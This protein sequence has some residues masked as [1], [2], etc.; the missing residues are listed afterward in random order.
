MKIRDTLFENPNKIDADYVFFFLIDHFNT[1]DFT[2]QFFNL[3][4]SKNVTVDKV[5]FLIT[6]KFKK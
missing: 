6:I 2:R 4:I 3:N 1:N 5:L